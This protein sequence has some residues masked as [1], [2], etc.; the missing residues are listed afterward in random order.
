MSKGKYSPILGISNILWLAFITSHIIYLI[1]GYSLTM[2]R[3]DDMF[4]IS[5]PDNVQLIFLILCVLAAI[6]IIMG[7]FIWLKIPAPFLKDKN[8]S[9]GKGEGNKLMQSMDPDARAIAAMGQTVSIILF[10]FFESIGIY[11]LLAVL[12]GCTY[13]TMVP[14]IVIS[15][16]CLVLVRPT[17]QFFD[18]IGERMRELKL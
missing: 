13:L 1:I 5:I 9:W 6:S 14:F 12:I 10:A 4:V 2:N 7:F 18:R 16:I 11:G 15:M 8:S 3:G 17:E